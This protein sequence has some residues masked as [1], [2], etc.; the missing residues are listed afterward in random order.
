MKT[1]RDQLKS[2]V[3]ECLLEILNEGLGVNQTSFNVPA[4]QPA[5][6]QIVGVAEQRSRQQRTARQSFDPVLDRRVVPQ[7]QSRSSLQ[8]TAINEAIKREAGGNAV[9]HDILADTA[10]TTLSTMMSNGDTGNGSSEP[11]SKLSQTEQFNGTPEQVFGEEV[12][13]RWAN[14]AFVS[15][16]LKNSA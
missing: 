3:K 1:T 11:S 16:P 12:A 14:L 2:I 13:S 6:R 9:M 5:R 7:Q 4:A 8:S 15:P 10:R